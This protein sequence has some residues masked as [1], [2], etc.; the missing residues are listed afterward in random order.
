MS[1]IDKKQGAVKA[2]EVSVNTAQEVVTTV[3]NQELMDTT[4]RLAKVN[5]D[6]FRRHQC[7]ALSSGELTWDALP[8]PQLKV[9][10]TTSMEF[11]ILINSSSSVSR[12]VRC[13]FQPV[14]LT[15]W[16]LSSYSYIYLE[17]SR[18][19][20]ESG[21][22]IILTDGINGAGTAGRRIR[23][24][25]TLPRIKDANDGNPQDTL[26]I[27]LVYKNGSN[28]WWIPSGM[29]WPDGTVS[30][31]GNTTRSVNVPLGTIVGLHLQGTTDQPV[32]IT[33][34]YLNTNMPGWW[35]CD[36]ATQPLINYVGST[37]NGKPTPPL[38]NPV[39]APSRD[40]GRFIRGSLKSGTTGGS[41]L[42]TLSLPQLP[43]H[44]HTLVAANHGAHTHVIK[45]SPLGLVYI[46]PHNDAGGSSTNKVAGSSDADTGDYLTDFNSHHHQLTNSPAATSH[47]NIPQSV[48]LVYIMKVL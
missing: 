28:I 26:A 48:S 1:T 24:S 14:S 12:S 33:Q 41:D 43:R 11:L 31:I 46:S 27:P 44:Y 2:K 8:T 37:L 6:L 23:A 32:A 20:L 4:D 17:L 45:T 5:E 29:L 21:S 39:A 30:T 25:A 15:T 22:A 10:S 34:S 35:L 47:E 16:D 36:A 40:K 18:A 9:P 19:N 38:N 13:Q 7:F 3:A 42:V